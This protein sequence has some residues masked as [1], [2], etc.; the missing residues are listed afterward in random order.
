VYAL[1]TKTKK[2]TSFAIGSR[3]NK[4]LNTVLQTLKIAE[5]K[6]IYTDGLKNYLYL[7]DKKIHCTKRFSTNHIERKNLT[8]RTHLKRL[9]RRTICFSKSKTILRAILKIYLWA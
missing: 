9:N 6:T 1:E 4:T 5:A 3:T 2:V 7:I 8:I